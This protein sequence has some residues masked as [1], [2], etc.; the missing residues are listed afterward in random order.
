MHRELTEHL[1]RVRLLHEDDVRKGLSFQIDLAVYYF[2][3]HRLDDAERFLRGL[4]DHS[5]KSMPGFEEHPYRIFAKLGLG[6]VA[7][8]RDDAAKSMTAL[9]KVLPAS[10]PAGGGLRLTGFPPGLVIDHFEL[11]RVVAEALNRNAKNLRVEKFP[12]SAAALEPLRKP[13]ELGRP[14]RKADGPKKG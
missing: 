11:R 2:K 10:Q 3:H 5:S 9:V 14:F 7:S 6:L 4:Q 13:P 1:Q 8:F 12:E